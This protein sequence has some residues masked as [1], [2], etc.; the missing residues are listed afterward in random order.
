MQAFID[1]AKENPEAAIALGYAVLNV[2]NAVLRPRA[3]WAGGLLDK[4]H[5]LLD[6][7]SVTRRETLKLPGTKTKAGR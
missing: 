3:G 7:V 5:L 4:A 2:L 1:W 6:W